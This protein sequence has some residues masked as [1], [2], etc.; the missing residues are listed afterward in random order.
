M[1][2]HV[3]LGRT[4]AEYVLGGAQLG[5]DYGITN[6]RGMPDLARVQSILFAGAEA[7]LTTIDTAAAYGAS[8]EHIGRALADSELLRSRLWPITKLDPMPQAATLS[9][10]DL[11]QGVRGS[12]ETSLARLRL[13]TLPLV[14]LHRAEHRTIAG[15]AVWE[16][17]IRFRGEGMIEHLGVSAYDPIQAMSALVDPDV[18]A[19]QIQVNLLDHRHLDAGVPEAAARAGTALFIRS[20][21]LQGLLVDPAETPAGVPVDLRKHLDRFRVVAAEYGRSP[22]SLAVAFA[23]AIP[24]L[25]GIVVGAESPDQVRMNASLWDEPAVDAAEFA[26]LRELFSGV[27][28]SL[29]DPS[30]WSAL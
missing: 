3:A 5:L 7:G 27:P 18:A 12:I 20:A 10:H 24:G 13:S 2:T 15:G 9:R 4:S 8:E 23:R 22:R 6:R 1:P 19:V 16:S 29:T 25:S 17:L 26:R 28:E 14:L 21:F 30:A 11:V